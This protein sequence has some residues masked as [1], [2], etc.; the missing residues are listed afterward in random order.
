ME[1]SVGT[2]DRL[3]GIAKRT[4]IGL[5]ILELLLVYGLGSMLGALGEADDAQ[6][7][8]LLVGPISVVVSLFIFWRFG[9]RLSA[10][11]LALV[12]LSGPFWASTVFG[13]ASQ[14]NLRPFWAEAVVVLTW[15][16]WGLLAF[17]FAAR[18]TKTAS[19]EAGQLN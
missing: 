7:P 11:T 16:A 1:P 2:M 4:I 3:I 17:Q 9:N 10:W 18:L 5:L 15:P 13:P 8:I 12:V 14:Q 6:G 19:T